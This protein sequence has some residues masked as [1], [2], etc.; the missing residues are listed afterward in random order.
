MNLPTTMRALE[1]TAPAGPEAV[2]LTERAVPPPA[3]ARCSSVWAP[4]ASTSPM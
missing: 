1:V 3:L 2:R 4:L